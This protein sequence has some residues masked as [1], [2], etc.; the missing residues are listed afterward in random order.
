MERHTEYSRPNANA[1][2]PRAHA[3]LL[4]WDIG[5]GWTWDYLRKARMAQFSKR[6]WQ[7]LPGV[8]D[9]W[10]LQVLTRLFQRGDD[11]GAALGLGSSGYSLACHRRRFDGRRFR[12]AGVWR[13]HV[14][15]CA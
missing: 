12:A 15:Q 13:Q 11:S 7:R 14:Y 2:K 5:L 1:A 10:R 6:T 9:R 3:P 4:S 8:R